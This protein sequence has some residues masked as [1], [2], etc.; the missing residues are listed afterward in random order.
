MSAGTTVLPLVP[1][2]CPS[3]LTGQASPRM[4]SLGR[5]DHLS[6]ELPGRPPSEFPQD[7]PPPLEHC[8]IAFFPLFERSKY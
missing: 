5:E 6:L 7:A 2:S 1:L 8:Q 4:W 3:P